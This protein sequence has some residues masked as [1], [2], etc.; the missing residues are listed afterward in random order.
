MNI[1]ISGALQLISPSD[2]GS[3]TSGVVKAN[4]R[5]FRTQRGPLTPNPVLFF[6][7]ALGEFVASH[8][9]R[10]GG[11][12]SHRGSGMVEVSPPVQI[13]SDLAATARI[14]FHARAID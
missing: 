7:A 10:P 5:H 1:P 11:D 4:W 14:V 6:V 8:R 3:H 13:N 2:F 9:R 12:R